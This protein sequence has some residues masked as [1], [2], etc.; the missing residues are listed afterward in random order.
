MPFGKTK[1]SC[2]HLMKSSEL[3]SKEAETYIIILDNM[4]LCYGTKT[5]KLCVCTLSHVWLFATPWTVAHQAPLSMWFPRQEYW[6]GCHF[7]LQ[8]IFPTQGSNL[9]LLHCRVDFFYHWA[10]VKG[11]IK[12]SDASLFNSVTVISNSEPCKP[13]FCNSD[14]I[15]KF[16]LRV[17]TL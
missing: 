2:R 10:T 13:H 12:I 6:V 11:D 15:S 17:R 3:T 14:N 7:L 4:T 9:G 5:I 8:G 1:E 16:D